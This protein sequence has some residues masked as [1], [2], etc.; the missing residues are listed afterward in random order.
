M[1]LVETL[2]DLSLEIESS[3]RPKK[4]ITNYSRFLRELEISS[5]NITVEFATSVL[6]TYDELLENGYTL[7]DLTWLQRLFYSGKIRCDEDQ[8]SLYLVDSEHA[9]SDE[10]KDN[11]IRITSRVLDGNDQP[12]RTMQAV[13]THR[14]DLIDLSLVDGNIEDVVNHRMTRPFF[15]SPSG[16]ETNLVLPE[17]MRENLR[18]K[19]FI[20]FYA[21]LEQFIRR[22]QIRRE[23]DPRLRAEGELLLGTSDPAQDILSCSS[24]EN[25]YL[26]HSAGFLGS[27]EIVES[28]EALQKDFSLSLVPI[29]FSHY[30]NFCH[31]LLYLSDFHRDENWREIEAKVYLVSFEKE[32]HTTHGERLIGGGIQE[33]L[34]TLVATK[35]HDQ[36]VFDYLISLHSQN[37]DVLQGDKVSTV[38]KRLMQSP[39]L[40]TLLLQTDATVPLLRA[41][42]A[43][44]IS[45][46]EIQRANVGHS[47]QMS[48]LREFLAASEEFYSVLAPYCREDEILEEYKLWVVAGNDLE[49]STLIKRHFSAHEGYTAKLREKYS[50]PVTF[51][52]Q[53]PHVRMIVQAISGLD[54]MLQSDNIGSLELA[55]LLPSA[56]RDGIIMPKEI[57]L[58]QR[59]SDNRRMY[60]LISALQA[61]THKHGGFTLSKRDVQT[62]DPEADT[63]V[64][65]LDAFDDPFLAGDIFMTLEQLRVLSKVGEEWSGIAYPLGQYSAKRLDIMDKLQ[66][67]HR[68]ESLLYA[69]ASC[70]FGSLAEK[71]GSAAGDDS[72][73]VENET[74]E[75]TSANTLLVSLL[76]R[77]ETCSDVLSTLQLVPVLYECIENICCAAEDPIL[78]RSDRDTKNQTVQDLS[79][80][81]QKVSLG[82]YKS[83]RNSPFYVYP[84]GDSQSKVYVEEAPSF[85]TPIIPMLLD[86]RSSD[87]NS[88][89]L[90]LQALSPSDPY[91]VRRQSRGHLDHRALCRYKQDLRAGRTPNPNIFKRKIVERR[92]VTTV[93]GLNLSRIL[94]TPIQGQQ[95]SEELQVLSLGLLEGCQMLDDALGIY[96]YSGKGQDNVSIQSYK[97]L[98]DEYDLKV[99]HKLAFLAG[100]T[101]SRCGAVYRHFAEVLSH[102]P[103]ESLRQYID[104]CIDF[105]PKDEGYVGDYALEDSKHAVQGMRN[106][107]VNAQCVLIHPTDEG[108]WRAKNVFGAQNV[109]VSTISSLGEDVAKLYVEM[110]G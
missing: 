72:F 45:H 83:F 55:R 6:E 67:G 105:S 1:T 89:V 51:A 9:F 43:T 74:R 48:S 75:T 97:D 23:K 59:H 66:F 35:M 15:S 60:Q 106:Q 3:G 38:G 21:D 14:N 18:E 46:Y 80:D 28:F 50:R 29:D 17:N 52:S 86:R 36:E 103:G 13:V 77:A 63:L 40:R 47:S 94:N 71:I 61:G 73:A 10:D 107:G 93:L 69:S 84:E 31:E 34:S 109:V 62:C 19:S 76:Q 92:D 41:T 32:Q 104:V 82:V 53:E 49:D 20:S 2:S 30:F 68:S 12:L 108:I 87:V 102:H 95:A 65:F 99:Q 25:L 22:E 4:R 98:L 70:A 57:S 39:H 100:D 85:D 33:Y 44:T 91:I 5:R 24:V 37:P 90:Q 101:N 78:Y 16:G 79:M 54:V 64:D 11:W 81:D 7:D 8:R 96:G 42:Y 58:Y 26:F 88:I 27:A 56:H 110:S